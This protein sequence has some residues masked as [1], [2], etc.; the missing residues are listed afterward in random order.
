MAIIPRSGGYLEGEDAVFILDVNE[1]YKPWL[2][3][4]ERLF[5][6]MDTRPYFAR[7]PGRQHQHL[8]IEQFTPRRL[9]ASGECHSEPNIQM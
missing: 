1:N 8:K 5:S 7:A 9:I 2:V 3:E 6:A 4:S